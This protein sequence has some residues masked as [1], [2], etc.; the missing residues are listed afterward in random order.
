MNKRG[1]LMDR[2]DQPSTFWFYLL[3]VLIFL[4]VLLAAKSVRSETYA[5]FCPEIYL[6]CPDRDFSQSR[7]LWHLLEE[8]GA[9]NWEIAGLR[10][11]TNNLDSKDPLDVVRTDCGSSGW[12]H[13]RPNDG[14]DGFSMGICSEHECPYHDQEW[15]DWV[16]ALLM[17]DMEQN[18]SQLQLHKWRQI[19]DL[20]INRAP[21][22]CRH[23]TRC[24]ISLVAIANSIPSH[25]A[26][27]GWQTEWDPEAMMN[28]YVQRR[29]TRHRQRRVSRVR[30]Q[31]ALQED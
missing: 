12:A 29:P 16:L 14:C 24:M 10:A 30:E 4:V 18:Q 17:W 7:N 11:I 22:R 19:M 5:P 25:A 21:R 8:S 31:W 13:R 1:I 9:E 28:E 2:N 6:E 26:G 23:R 27:I 20:A 15:R 3:I